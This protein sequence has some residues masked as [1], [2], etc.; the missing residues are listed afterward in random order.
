MIKALKAAIL[1]SGAPTRSSTAAG[2]QS[3]VCISTHLFLLR[4][5]QLTGPTDHSYFDSY[6]PD[7][8]SPPDELSGWD[9]DFWD[10]L[11]RLSAGFLPP[12][13]PKRDGRSF[14]FQAILHHDVWRPGWR[15]E[16]GGPL[17]SA[18][19]WTL[20]RT[21]M[22]VCRRILLWVCLWSCNHANASANS[23]TVVLAC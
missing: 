14:S 8:D 20:W 18:G 15:V 13:R 6:P 21:R 3:W 4:C 17:Q 23:G 16:G 7:E 11:L 10:R 9:M 12:R 22:N 2:L 19:S 5:L 1:D